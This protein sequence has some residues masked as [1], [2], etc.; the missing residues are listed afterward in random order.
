[1]VKHSVH[2]HK[3]KSKNQIDKTLQKQF[4]TRRNTNIST[5]YKKSNPRE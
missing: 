1:M 3:Q 4:D 5:L 2:E